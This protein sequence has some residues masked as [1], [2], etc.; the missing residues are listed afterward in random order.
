MF[1][2]AFKVAC[3]QTPDTYTDDYKYRK[4]INNGKAFQ[5]MPDSQT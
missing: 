1:S 5:I 2:F 4:N 3:P